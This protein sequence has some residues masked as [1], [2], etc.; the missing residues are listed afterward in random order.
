M[1]SAPVTCDMAESRKWRLR[2]F[3]KKREDG[4]RRVEKGV[5]ELEFREKRNTGI[6]FLFGLACR[7]LEIGIS[8]HSTQ[9]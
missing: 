3:K 9:Q 7:G 2:G 6:K 4:W 5:L 8:C 1:A